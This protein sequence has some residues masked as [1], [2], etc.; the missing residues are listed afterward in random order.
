MNTFF[1]WFPT[2]LVAFSLIATFFLT[3]WH[4]R[5]LGI[6]MKLLGTMPVSSATDWFLTIMFIAGGW[7]TVVRKLVE[8]ILE[9]VVRVFL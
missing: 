5:R 9:T 1:E 2:V 8:W 3:V 4:C 6:G 7:F